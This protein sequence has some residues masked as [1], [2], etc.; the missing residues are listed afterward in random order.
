MPD[1]V[2]LSFSIVVLPPAESIRITNMSSVI[3]S[4][5]GTN[6]MSGLSFDLT[7]RAATIEIPEKSTVH[8][9]VIGIKEGTAKNGFPPII[10]G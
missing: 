4:L 1:K 6:R 8:S 9:K 10:K 2:D 5:S 3:L 7:S